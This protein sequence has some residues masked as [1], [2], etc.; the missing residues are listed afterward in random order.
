MTKE[1]MKNC[2]ALGECEDGEFFNLAHL[3]ENGFCTDELCF[4]REVA[5]QIVEKLNILIGEDVCL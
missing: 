4:P 3:D 1:K 2:I 5:K